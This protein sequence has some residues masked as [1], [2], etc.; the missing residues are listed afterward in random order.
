M[1][2]GTPLGRG[3]LTAIFA[4]SGASGLVYEVVWMRALRLLV[5]STTL[6]HAIAISAFDL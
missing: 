1:E 6:S 4:A 2:A 5:G 3:T